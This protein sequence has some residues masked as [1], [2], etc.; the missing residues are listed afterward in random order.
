MTTVVYPRGLEALMSGSVN[1]SSDTIKAQMVTS[2]YTYSSSHQYASSLAGLVGTAATLASKT[3]T[4]GVFD[5]ADVTYSSV[6]AGSTV[7]GIAIY[8][9]TGSSATSPLLAFISMKG[10]TTALAIVTDGGNIVISWNASGIFK[11]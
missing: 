6:A 11:I 4:A 5:A 10:D 7:T 9:D 8:K 1:L 3:V 2:A